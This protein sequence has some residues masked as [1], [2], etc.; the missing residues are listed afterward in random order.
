MTAAAPVPTKKIV[1]VGNPNVG[2][3]VIFRLLTGNYVMVSNFPGTTVEVSRGKMQL[4]GIAYE[5][6]D[7]PGVNSLIPQSEDE[8]VTFEILLREKPDVIIQVAD[9]KSLRRT[10]LITSELVELGIPMILVLNMMDEAEERGVDIDTAGLSRLFS[11]P[12]VQTVAIYSQGRR[13]LLNAIQ[14]AA[15]PRDLWKNT[16]NGGEIAKL[17]DGIAVAPRFLTVEWLG[18]GNP[19]LDRTVEH[20]LGAQ[21]VSMIAGSHGQLPQRTAAAAGARNM[22][23][24]AT[25]FSTKLWHLSSTRGRVILSRPGARSTPVSGW[26]FSSPGC[27]SSPGMRSGAFWGRALHTMS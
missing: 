26:V 18:L 2:K 24:S 11:I 21:P 22:P 20:A 10:I 12:V 25:A 8:R 13:Q 14:N 5:V 17:L 3:S 9:A 16:D 23:R 7:T 19:D 1:L 4:G 27:F 6:V 15:P